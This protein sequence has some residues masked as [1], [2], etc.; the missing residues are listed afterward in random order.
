M[1]RFVTIRLWYYSTCD[2]GIISIYIYINIE[3]EK[4]R[5]RPRLLCLALSHLMLQSIKGFTTCIFRRSRFLQETVLMPLWHIPSQS[6]YASLRFF[7]FVLA[8]SLE[9][10]VYV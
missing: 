10:G 8:G 5:E 6:S 1:L 3:R 2:Y 4:E 9:F 7:V